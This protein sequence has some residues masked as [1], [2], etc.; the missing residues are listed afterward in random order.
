MKTRKLHKRLKSSIKKKYVKKEELEKLAKEVDKLQKKIKQLE[1]SLASGRSA[2]PVATANKKKPGNPPPVAE[3]A[4]KAVAGADRLTRIRGIGPVIEKKLHD[5]GITTFSQ[6][7]ANSRSSLSRSWR[8][9]FSASV[10]AS[11]AWRFA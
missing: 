6:I 7:A 11:S 4:P 9:S 2:P 8:G 5:L 10:R 3:E 1:T